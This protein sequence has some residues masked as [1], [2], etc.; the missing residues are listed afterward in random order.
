MT[1]E[2]RNR[3]QRQ[4]IPFSKNL[5]SI[6]QE[7]RLTQRAIAHKLSVPPSVVNGWTTGS[8]PHDLLKIV[9]L[10]DELKVDFCWLLTGKSSKPRIEY[11]GT[12][13][14]VHTGIF[15]ITAIRLNLNDDE[16]R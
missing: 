13:D 8:V 10:A 3:R 1:K 7:R 9:E 5:I 15:K 2:Q 14:P 6:M 4:S 11:T 12:I 16:Y